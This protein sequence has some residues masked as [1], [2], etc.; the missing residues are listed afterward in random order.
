MLRHF[1]AE[2]V[3]Q[4]VFSGLSLLNKEFT[5]L[6]CWCCWPGLSYRPGAADQDIS[7]GE[8]NVHISLSK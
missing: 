3:F 5:F 1:L 6:L 4:A 7:A 8:V 2:V